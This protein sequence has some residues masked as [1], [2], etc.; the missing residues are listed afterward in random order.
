M[1][2][3]V[4]INL[5][6]H[7]SKYWREQ[8]KKEAHKYGAIVDIPFPN[9]PAEATEDD[10]RRLCDATVKKVMGYSPEAVLCQGN[11]RWHFKL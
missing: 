8:Q 10:I 7:H 1:N 6:N 2:K 4:F 11:L 9:V 5:T 3:P